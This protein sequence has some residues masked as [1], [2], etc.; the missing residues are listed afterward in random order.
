MIIIENWP[1][2]WICHFELWNFD[3]RFEINDPKNS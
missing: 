3:I 1:P 2:F